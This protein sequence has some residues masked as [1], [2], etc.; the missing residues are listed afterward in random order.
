MKIEVRV[1]FIP[2]YNS[3]QIKKI[4]EFLKGVQNITKVRVLPYHNF[5][6]SK[7]E[8]LDMKNTLPKKLPDETEI[9]KAEELLDFAK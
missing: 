2:E 9:K 5:A 7:Y 3:G 1:P 4:A 8:S 6:G